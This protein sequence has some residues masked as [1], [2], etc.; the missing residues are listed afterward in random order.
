M[1]CIC[2]VYLYMI[3]LT[4]DDL[5]SLDYKP[6]KFYSYIV[7]LEIFWL[8]CEFMQIYHKS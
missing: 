4:D 6:N 3:I 5:Y 8:T 2:Y 1:F 7:L